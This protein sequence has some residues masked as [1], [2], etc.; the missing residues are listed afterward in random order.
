[1]IAAVL[2]A[3]IVIATGSPF[4]TS[5][6]PAYILAGFSGIICL[7]LLVIQPMLAAGYIPGLP[8]PLARRWHRL[9]GAAICVAVMLHVGGLFVTSPPD[10]MDALLLVA[11]TPFSVYGVTAF[12]GVILTALLVLLRKRSG[13]RLST[14]RIIHNGLAFVV[15]LSTAIHALQI[16]GTMGTASKWVVCLCMLAITTIALVDL[17]VIKPWLKRRSEPD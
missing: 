8:K 13:L 1:M 4:L 5:R 14:W 2:I 7:E 15:V 3:P 9:T 16:E 12:W 6:N 11:P 10:T 17:R